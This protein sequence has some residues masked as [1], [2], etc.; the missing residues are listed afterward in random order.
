M[1]VIEIKQ[2][3]INTSQ[4]EYKI[5]S[6]ILNISNNFSITKENSTYYITSQ[7]EN[8]CIKFSLVINQYNHIAK[9]VYNEGK[10]KYNIH[11]IARTLTDIAEDYTIA[12][13]KK[14]KHKLSIIKSENNKCP[15]CNSQLTMLSESELKCKNNCYNIFNS[16]Y[17]GSIDFV[18]TIFG[19]EHSIYGDYS[20]KS[21][22][23]LINKIYNHISNWK[24]NEKYL[25][26][27]L[28]GEY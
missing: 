8:A 21:K 23:R 20:I 27:I 7:K 11:A 22:V 6:D 4:E 19:K 10:Q 5:L 15:I 24:K 26:K 25:A 18:V 9:V 2:F 3:E 14:I 16:N 1:D 17:S 28:K 13:N 12:T